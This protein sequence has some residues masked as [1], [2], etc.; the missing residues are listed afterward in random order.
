MTSASRRVD[1]RRSA[2]RQ[3]RIGAD[4]AGAVV[5][6]T[7]CVHPNMLLGPTGPRKR[8]IDR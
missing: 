3:P 4:A 1:P 7:D 8:K 6:A 5:G 2:G